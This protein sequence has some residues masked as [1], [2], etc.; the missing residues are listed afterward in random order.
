MAS[1]A[2]SKALENGLSGKSGDSVSGSL[3]VGKSILSES[4]KVILVIHAQRETFS[5]F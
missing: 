3:P 5:I 4:V 1:V 2:L